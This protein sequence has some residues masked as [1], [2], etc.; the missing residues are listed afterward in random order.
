MG[1]TLDTVRWFG[2]IMLGPLATPFEFFPGGAAL[3]L[4]KDMTLNAIIDDTVTV[5]VRGQPGANKQQLYYLALAA[6]NGMV[7]RVVQLDSPIKPSF[8]MLSIEY[9]AAG[10][11]VRCTIR[12]TWS[13]LSVNVKNTKVFG[14]NF[15]DGLAVYRGPQCGVVGGEF[16][17]VG[18]NGLRGVPSTVAPGAPDLPFDGQT[19]LTDC[20]RVQ[21]PKPTAMT[22]NP[23]PKIPLKNPGELIDSP[24]PKPPGDNRSRGVVFTGETAPRSTP[25]DCCAKIN[26][27]LPMVFA[28]LSGAAT[29]DDMTFANPTAGPRGK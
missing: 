26:A 18:T 13:M 12:Y 24:N 23:P 8:G 22:Q 1:D 25:G 6:A 11:W 21:E 20:P 4:V 19:I 9:D 15:F 10:N 17:F 16:D 14:A 27:L 7:R 3:D 29:T 5:E 28:V 2:R